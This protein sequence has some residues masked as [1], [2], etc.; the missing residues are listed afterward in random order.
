VIFGGYLQYINMVRWPFSGPDQDMHLLRLLPAPFACVILAACGGGSSGPAP[1][2]APG[3]QLVPSVTSITKDISLGDELGITL[4]GSWTGSNLGSSPVYLQLRDSANGLVGETRLL[5]PSASLGTVTTSAALGPGEHTGNLELRA[6]ADAQCGSVYAGSTI[7]LP[8]TLNV[9]EIADWKTHQRDA[10]HRGFV[11]ITLKPSSFAFAWKWARPRASEPIG[12]INAVAT[13]GQKVYI[14]TDVYFGE[15]TLYA[16]DEATGS[17]AWKR[18]F[19]VM[20]ALAPPAVSNGRVYAATSGHENTFLWTFDSAKGDYIAKA[21][22]S[23]QWPHLMAPTPSGSQVFT[24]AGYYGG[25]TYAFST[26]TNTLEWTHSAGGVWDMFTP[27]VDAA[28]VYHYNG[29]ALYVIDRVTGATSF[30]IGDPF[31]K[32]AGFSYH[33]SPILGTRNNVLALAGGA[34][35]WRASSN[36]EAYDQRVIG[37]FSLTRKTHEWASS[38]AYQTTPAVANGVVYAGR[39][40]PMSLDAI[41]EATGKV[42]WSWAPSGADTSF[43]R[44]V[45]VTNNLLFVSTDRA[46]YAIDLANRNPVWSY[47]QPGM[48]AISASRTLFIA[49]GATS[50]D[51]GLV[52]I[53]LK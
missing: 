35:S 22:F 7:S 28:A 20:P 15:A 17:E 18:S 37:S 6:C 14:T 12:G 44:N 26:Q 40:S 49:T 33:G 43:H 21:A 48:L 31:G 51:G 2:P 5:P 42:L 41:D 30:S 34:S 25:E 10:A 19:G 36:A 32:N 11:P 3:V 53:K 9:A 38:N 8:Y 4:G 24:G 1:A 45:V 23:G 16:L 47:P 39:N 27:A 29:L 52:A 13:A 46:V 50:S